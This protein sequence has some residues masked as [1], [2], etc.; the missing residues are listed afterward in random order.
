MVNA[1]AHLKPGCGRAIGKIKELIDKKLDPDDTRQGV[2]QE[3]LGS[4]SGPTL[5]ELVC[6][7]AANQDGG[8]PNYAGYDLVDR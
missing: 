4:V 6:I 5:A 2:T 1:L 8:V 3:R 7:A